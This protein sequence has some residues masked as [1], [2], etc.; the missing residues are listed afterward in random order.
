MPWLVFNGASATFTPSQEIDNGTAKFDLML[1]LTD[2]PQ[3]IAGHLKYRSD[4][5]ERGTMEHL[6]ENWQRF[7]KGAMANPDETIYSLL[8]SSDTP[9]RTNPAISENSRLHTS[10]RPAFHPNGRPAPAPT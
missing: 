6:I 8:L 9:S 4:L 5:F 1:E 2:G 7:L 3:G 10:P